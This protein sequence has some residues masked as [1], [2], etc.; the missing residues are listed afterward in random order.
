L[1]KNSKEIP[2]GFTL[3]IPGDEENS[4][5]TSEDFTLKIPEGLKKIFEEIPEGFWRH[6]RSTKKNS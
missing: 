1:K 4:R 6:Q 5:E 3:K 2:E